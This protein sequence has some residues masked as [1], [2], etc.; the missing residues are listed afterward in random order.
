MNPAVDVRKKGKSFNDKDTASNRSVTGII[1]FFAVKFRADISVHDSLLGFHVGHQ[2]T[3][4]RAGAKRVMCCLNGA[5]MNTLQMQVDDT[6]QLK[7]YVD[8]IWRGVSGAARHTRAGININ[9]SESPIDI[10]VFSFKRMPC[11]ARKKRN[12][13][14]FTR[15]VTWY[16][17]GNKYWG[18]SRFL[19]PQ[20]RCTKTSL[21]QRNGRK[22][23]RREA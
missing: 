6:D 13:S 23:R 2:T 5:A 17:G 15:Q 18:G 10:S 4:K 9:Y 16:R 3:T 22:K 14:P 20:Q 11:S 12:I 1:L 8:G 7:A 21:V 19:K